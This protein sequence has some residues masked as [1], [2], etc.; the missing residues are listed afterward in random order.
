MIDGPIVVVGSTVVDRVYRVAMLPMP[1]ENAV[2][3]E[4][5]V[6]HG[7]KGANQAVA[8]RRLGAPVRLLTC[9]G[10]DEDGREAVRALEA[11]GLELAV[12]RTGE[13]PTGH[14]AVVVDE[15][16]ENLLAVHLGANGHLGPDAIEAERDG[17]AGASVLVTQLETP[18]ETVRAAAAAATAEEVV[19]VLNAAPLAPPDQ[20]GAEEDVTGLLDLFDVV[21]VNRTE[22]ERL[23][24]VGVANLDDAL[25]ALRALHGMGVPDPV[26][27]LGAAGVV[28][29][30]R[31][32]AA[33]AAAP[34]VESVDATGAGD[35]FVG[36]LAALLREEREMSEAVDRACRYA[37][38]ATLQTGARAGYLD[39]EAFDRS[40]PADDE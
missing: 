27:T 1:G 21:V 18:V 28:Y 11:E 9:V 4:V 22:A 8:A 13:A 16:G 31:G 6:S 25:A 15:V 40:V 24:G 19:K 20:E 7:G 3:G 36:A 35:A 5:L 34:E 38:H 23:S 12:A 33:H 32:R 10:E 29:L 26:V 30:D 2:A 14:A 39:R 17:L 37:A